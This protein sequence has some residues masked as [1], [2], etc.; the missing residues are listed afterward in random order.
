M[1]IQWIRTS[2]LSIT[3]HLVVGPEHVQ[4]FRGG[5][6]F[7]AHRLLYHSTVGLRVTTLSSGLSPATPTDIF[8]APGL[9]GFAEP[10]LAGRGEVGASRG[11]GGEDVSRG[12]HCTAPVLNGIAEPNRPRRGNTMWDA[13]VD[14]HVDTI[15][16]ATRA[17]HNEGIGLSFSNT[18][19]KHAIN[20]QPSTQNPQPSP[21]TPHPSPLTPPPAPLTPQPSTFTPQTSPPQP[22]TLNHQPSRRN[23][24]AKW[25]VRAPAGTRTRVHENQRNTPATAIARNVLCGRRHDTAWD[26]ARKHTCSLQLRVRMQS[27][28]ETSDAPSTRQSSTD[29]STV[30][31]S[32]Y[33]SHGERLPTCETRHR[34]HGCSSDLR[35]PFAPGAATRRSSRGPPRG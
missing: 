1:M 17:L 32:R 4:W 3:A 26:L 29:P 19:T 18:T 34:D 8:A 10:S 24:Q 20:H 9:T 7:K 27:A 33:R 14:D 21:L 25:N 30:P 12:D 2:R 15:C 31:K 13:L 6:V 23:R 16:G 28:K 22:L 5:L 11:E 35:N